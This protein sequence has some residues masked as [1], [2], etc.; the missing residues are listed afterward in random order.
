MDVLI[1]FV[2][3]LSGRTLE[4]A[5]KACKMSDEGMSKVRAKA[6]M[7]DVC[8]AYRYSPS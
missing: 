5:V 4:N 2:A 7:S 8:N 3:A 6:W 1:P